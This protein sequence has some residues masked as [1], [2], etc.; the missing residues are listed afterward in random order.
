M[1]QTCLLEMR[2]ISKTFPGVKALSNVN[3]KVEKGSVH[4]LVGENGAGKS[5]LIKILCGLHT[6]YEGDVLI[7]GKKVVFK[8]A[9]D[10]LAHG[11]ATIHQELNQVPA[12]TI[13][14]NLFL[15]REP[16]QK[17]KLFIDD[18]YIYKRAQELL[19][20]QKLP[21]KATTLVKDLSVSQMQMVEITKAVSA[22][23]QIIIMDEPTS[24]ITD[25]E[26]DIL[27]ERIAELKAKGVAIIYIS[28]RLDELFRI[29]D[30]ITIL[31]DGEYIDTKKVGELDKPAIIKMMVGRELDNIYPPK[32][33]VVQK[34]KVVLELKN[35]TGK[36]RFEDVSF[37][38]HAGE[39]L[40]LAGLMGAGRTETAR[41]MFG[42]DPIDSGEMLLD[43]KPIR[44]KNTTDA[45]KHGIMM[46]SE[47]RKRYGLVLK[48]SIG[49]NI[50]LPNLRMFKGKLL[51][52]AKKERAAEEV[53]FK[54][55]G[56]KAPNMDVAASSLS[57]GNQQKVVLAKWILAN[58]KVFILDEPTRGI[59][60]GAKYEIYKIM[61]DLAAKGMAIIMIS[62][63]LPEILGMC[64][65]V[66]VMR[67]HRVTGELQRDELTQERVMDL[68]TTDLA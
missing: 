53:V 41:A 27:F 61:N 22:N 19:D 40:G 55:L 52:N 3:L 42:L 26:V 39:I 18:K 60:V 45:L 50:G 15:G 29:G 46:A 59:D 9:H 11:I 23:A 14:E 7:N 6:D 28:H 38:V 13:A 33:N 1:E 20:Q 68:A 57:G 12:M 62:S 48:R 24:A 63:E 65:R 32:T 4:V 54:E 37:K 21:F 44:I 5:T 17:N 58:P 16:L 25:T 31:R 51:L 10:A 43:G 34:D 47:D 36:G 66:M 49:D 35:L 64:D 2:N 67:E 30:D 8:N 56:V